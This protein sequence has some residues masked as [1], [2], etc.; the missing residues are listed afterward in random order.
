MAALDHRRN[1]GRRHG[2]GWLTLALAAWLCLGMAGPIAAADD[3][4]SSKGDNPIFLEMKG[5]TIP[6]IR[7][8]RLE[9]YVHVQVT[10]ELV[11]ASAKS[12]AEA[13]YPRLKDRFYR[14]L[15]DYF[16]YQRPGTKGINIRVVKARLMRAGVRAIGKNKIKAVLIQGAFERSPT[17]K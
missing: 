7:N 17:S 1:G 16:G 9:K 10:L 14:A 15:Y 8:G 13:S 11:D 6:V 5:L 12:L 4:D 2:L 3:E